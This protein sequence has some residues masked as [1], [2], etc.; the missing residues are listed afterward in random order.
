MDDQSVMIL[1]VIVSFTIL[2][3]A[4]WIVGRM[5]DQEL[6]NRKDN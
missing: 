4:S 1:V 5:D 6:T 3:M 2:I